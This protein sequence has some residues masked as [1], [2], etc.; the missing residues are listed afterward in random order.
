M[1]DIRRFT[2]NRWTWDRTSSTF[3][4]AVL[5]KCHLHGLHPLTKKGF[6]LGEEEGSIPDQVYEWT[7]KDEKGNTLIVRR[8]I[9]ELD[10]PPHLK[11]ERYVKDCEKRR[12]LAADPTNEILPIPFTTGT[13]KELE[14]TVTQIWN[15]VNLMNM[16]YGEEHKK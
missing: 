1:I 5:E 8:L 13:P 3:E 6:Q 7:R 4:Q 12:R 2:R 11:L 14:E 15:R 9:V 10:G 16:L